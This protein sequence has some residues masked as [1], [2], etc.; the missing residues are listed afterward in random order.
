MSGKTERDRYED[1]RP[2]DDEGYLGDAGDQAN[3]LRFREERDLIRQ[4]SEHRYHVSADD[5]HR[6]GYSRSEFPDD[7]GSPAGAGGTE[8]GTDDA[9]EGEYLDVE[10]AEASLARDRNEIDAR[11]RGA[12]GEE[13]ADS[14]D[15]PYYHGGSEI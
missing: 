9:G 1:D 8:V 5:E 15:D 13:D 2:E 11:L 7:A 4:Q 3:D 14:S 10:E 12:A 6:A